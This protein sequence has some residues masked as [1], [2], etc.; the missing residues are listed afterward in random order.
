MGHLTVGDVLVLYRD[1]V[2]LSPARNG[3]F[4]DECNPASWH[5]EDSGLDD[6][7]TTT[8]P[9]LTRIGVPPLTSDVVQ[10]KHLS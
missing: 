9:D 10:D 1:R 4:R 7:A 3:P 6:Q 5:P 2:E 8:R